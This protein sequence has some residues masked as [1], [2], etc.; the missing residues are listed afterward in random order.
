MK[1]F[2]FKQYINQITRKTAKSKSILDVVY[3]KTAKNINSFIDKTVLSD[4]YLVGTTRYLGYTRPPSTSIKGRSYKNYSYD[5]AKNFHDTQ[6]QNLVFMYTDP[7][8]IWSKLL[9]FINNCANYLCPFRNMDVR[10]NKPSW[11]TNELI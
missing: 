7:N 1:T 4:H 3:I 8:M 9:V 11:I 2:G 6:Q 5:C 10:Q